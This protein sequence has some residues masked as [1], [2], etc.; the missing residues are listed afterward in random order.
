MKLQYIL[1][2]TFLFTTTTVCSCYSQIADGQ[3][4]CF[5]SRFDRTIGDDERCPGIFSMDS[6]VIQTVQVSRLE[7]SRV[8]V[9]WSAYS[10]EHDQS[11]LG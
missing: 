9:S 11:V 7:L 6:S 3:H 2:K 10:V 5:R 8:C 1:I 4:F